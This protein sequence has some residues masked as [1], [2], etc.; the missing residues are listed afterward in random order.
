MTDAAVA[1]GASAPAIQ[2][3]PIDT[4]AA[5]I[6]NPAE[7][8]NIPHSGEDG[9]RGQ[10]QT[11]AE[12]RSLDDIIKASVE[13]VTAK[14]EGKDLAAKEPPKPAAE[15][16]P[17]GEAG[18]DPDAKPE[19][20]KPV[21]Q[22]GPDGK[23]VSTKPAEQQAPAA[24]P[25]RPS[26]PHAE[27]P[28]RFSADAKAEWANAPE[29]VRAETHRMHREFEQ[30]YAK[31]REAAEAYNTVKDFDDYAKQQGGNLRQVLTNYASLEY[32]LVKGDDAAKSEALSKVFQRAGINPR[33]WA[34]HILG[35]TPDQ[36]DAEHH[37][38]LTAL[39]SEIASLKAAVGGVTTSI[40]QQ[41]AATITEGVSA[42]AKD[43]AH[44]RFDE[45][46]DSRLE[47]N[48]QSLLRSNLVP[49]N[50][51]PQARL[52]K[53]Y[54]LAD[55][56]NPA[57]QKPAP[58]TREHSPPAADAGT[59]SIAGSPAN[60]SDP[61]LPARKKGQRTSIDDAIKRGRAA[62]GV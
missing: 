32:A 47:H 51:A 42:F 31:Y 27:P 35:Q 8:G 6:P 18:K 9:Q 15:A 54:E 22:Q 11:G 4:G 60:G 23:F 17:K 38:E 21:R 53:A 14:G 26:G 57:A 2:P 36:R 25:Q 10:P 62:I 44:P 40:K 16:K 46:S 50:L 43:P 30:G 29:S 56:L 59:K 49:Q 28:A 24:D 39:R 20:A 1:A 5:R 41:Q 58:L 37:S 19:P 55:R 3:V 33:E 13:K 34:A 7:T 61:S 45:L 52:Q 12:R 48:I